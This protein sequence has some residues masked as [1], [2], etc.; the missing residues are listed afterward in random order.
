M[1]PISPTY[2]APPRTATPCGA[3][4]LRATATARLPPGGTAY[5]VPALVPTK[6]VPR[7]PSASERAC[8]SPLAYTLMRNPGGSRMSSRRGAAMHA[9]ET[10]RKRHATSRF[11]MGHPAFPETSMGA[12]RGAATR[13]APRRPG[14]PQERDQHHQ[15]DGRGEEEVERGE[16]EGLL[17]HE[18]V[19]SRVLR[20]LRHAE[21][22]ERLERRG[23]GRIAGRQPLHDVGV[24]HG[25]AVLP[26]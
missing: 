10:N 17:V 23:G 18:L 21:R 6:S 9:L 8:S 24:M 11:L 25:G 14:N 16:R 1:R 19:E 3:W 13:P 15:Q 12:G 20:L 7:S 26:Q 5:T 22:A 4:R 2:S